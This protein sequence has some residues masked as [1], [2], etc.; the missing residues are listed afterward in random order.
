VPGWAEAGSALVA[1]C[2]GREL[3]CATWPTRPPTR[4]AA[5]RA[6]TARRAREPGRGAREAQCGA[7]GHGAASGARGAVHAGCGA[8]GGARHGYGAARAE[9]WRGE[10]GALSLPRLARRDGDS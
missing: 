8:A 9:T 3:G 4:A 2:L 7:R 5:L 10:R 1:V 6:P